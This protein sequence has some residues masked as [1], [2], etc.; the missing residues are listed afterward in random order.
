MKQVTVMRF[1]SFNN[2]KK[3]S[4]KKIRTRNA[5]RSAWPYGARN[6]SKFAIFFFL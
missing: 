3:K 1:L 5:E 4:D 2:L 6:A